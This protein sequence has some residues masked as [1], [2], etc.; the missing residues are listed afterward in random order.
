M[1]FKILAI[2]FIIVVKFMNI[3]HSVNHPSFSGIF[4]TICHRGDVCSL[5]KGLA[6]FISDIHKFVAVQFWIYI[7]I[8]FFKRNKNSKKT[9]KNLKII[10]LIYLHCF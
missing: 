9:I 6:N 3:L 4:Y 5:E 2:P 7:L 1:S 10:F 8:N